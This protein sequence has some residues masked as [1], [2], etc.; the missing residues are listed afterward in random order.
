MFNRHPNLFA[1]IIFVVILLAGWT[2]L[3]VVTGS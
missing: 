1:A 3:S 2:F